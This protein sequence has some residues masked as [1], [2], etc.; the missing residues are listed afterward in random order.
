MGE[1]FVNS[2]H[3][4]KDSHAI[5]TRSISFDEIVSL[6]NFASIVGVIRGD[7]AIVVPNNKD[8]QKKRI[9]FLYI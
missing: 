7:W 9:R 8:I 5:P 2:I 4:G 6:Q 1:M 3:R